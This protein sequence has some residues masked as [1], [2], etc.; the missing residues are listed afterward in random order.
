M[1]DL[2]DEITLEKNKKDNIYVVVDRIIV[3][4]E[5]RGR[6]F[7][8]I[9]TSTKLAEGKVLINI[10]DGEEILMSEHYACPE[11]NFSL[12]ELEPRL[13]SFN[14]PYGACSDCKGLGFKQHIS[15]DLLIPDKNK[16]I[17][18]GG[19]KGFSTDQNMALTQ[20]E[21]VCDYYGIDLTK[22]IKDLTKRT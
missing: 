3:D 13:F 17:L 22:K 10:I 7:E 16:S 6:I 1:Y 19:I 2:S 18:E 20:L 21:T 8:A 15:L 5:E 4:E 11:C 12:P 14:A 9:E